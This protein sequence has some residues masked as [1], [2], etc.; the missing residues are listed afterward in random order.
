MN[1]EVINNKDNLSQE[2]NEINH[3]CQRK[4]HRLAKEDLIEFD[5][6]YSKTEFKII[7]LLLKKCWGNTKLQNVKF[8]Y[9]I[10]IHIVVSHLSMDS[11]IKEK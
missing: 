2:I 7:Y 4:I 6:I 11:S 9:V 5:E 1:Y 8:R 10:I 3:F